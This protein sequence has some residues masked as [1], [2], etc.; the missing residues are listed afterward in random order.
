M[1]AQRYPRRSIF[2]CCA[3]ILLIATLATSPAAA[4]QAQPAETSATPATTQPAQL[5]A[6]A[7]SDET[8]LR[9]VIAPPAGGGKA[10]SG[11][12]TRTDHRAFPF[13]AQKT[14]DGSGM[15][16]SFKDPYGN[17]FEFNAE[18]QGDDLVLHTGQATYM[19][20][21]ESKPLPPPNRGFG[22]G[23][24]APGRMRFGA[25]LEDGSPGQGVLVGEVFRDTPAARAGVRRKRRGRSVA[26]IA[27]WPG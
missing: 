4:Q 20:R 21:D 12:I 6:G 26:S 1:L 7:F 15:T 27:R 25:R 8:H 10:L 13:E 19:L 22:F 3:A 9:V 14:P 16:G 24:F 18:L 17:S 2:L 5:N 23:G 11:T